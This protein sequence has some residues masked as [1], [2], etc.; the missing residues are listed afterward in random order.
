MTSLPKW[1]LALAMALTLVLGA[2]LLIH[3]RVTRA[4]G[5]TVGGRYQLIYPCRAVDTR[6]GIGGPEMQAGETRE[7]NIAQCPTIG[8]VDAGAWALNITV[9]PDGP[10]GFLTA[11]GAGDPAA[12]PRPN[13]SILN[14][15]DGQVVANSAIVGNGNGAIN[16]YVSNP[17]HVI[18]DVTGY[19][20]T[21][22]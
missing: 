22:N 6:V 10:L 14:S 4:Q 12:W 15:W 5:P 13:T 18:I 19:F 17:T 3:P 1:N 2:N 7:F 8:T 9:V 16:V 21:L 11:W 20:N